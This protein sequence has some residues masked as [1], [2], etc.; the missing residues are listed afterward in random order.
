MRGGDE[1]NLAQQ[2]STNLLLNVDGCRVFYYPAC[3]LDWKPLHLFH[4]LCDVFLMCDWMHSQ[5]EVREAIKNIRIPGYENADRVNWSYP[6]PPKVMEQVTNMSGLPWDLAERAPNDRYP[7][8][9]YTRLNRISEL[10]DKPVHLIYFQGNPVTAYQNLFVAQ[11]TAPRFICLKQD[12]L[13]P[14]ELWNAFAALDGP[15]QWAIRANPYRP[16]YLLRDIS[17]P[18]VI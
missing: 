18:T 1:H 11:Q 14:V 4:S 16:S 17:Q 10:G 13:F 5:D 8:G 6:V 15:L 9:L 12:V 7:W 3:P 2:E